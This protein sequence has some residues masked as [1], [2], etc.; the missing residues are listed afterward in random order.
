MMVAVQVQCAAA[1]RGMYIGK[2]EKKQQKKNVGFS[3]TVV[4]RIHIVVY[5]LR[6]RRR[7]KR[8]KKIHIVYKELQ[9]HNIIR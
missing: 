2:A 4:R 1:G 5:T 7:K 8:W 6:D 9:T 3:V